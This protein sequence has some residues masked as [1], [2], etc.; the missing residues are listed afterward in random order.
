MRSLKKNAQSCEVY[1]CL[2]Q[3]S[4]EHNQNNHNH[5]YYPAFAASV[6]VTIWFF[7]QLSLKA[8]RMDGLTSCVQKASSRNEMRNSNSLSSSSLP[9]KDY[10]GTPL[11]RSNAKDIM[12]LSTMTMF[13]FSLS[14]KT[15]RSLMKNSC[16]WMQSYLYILFFMIF[17][18]G[19]IWSRIL[20][21]YSCTPA[22]KTMISQSQLSLSKQSWRQGLILT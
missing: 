10:M 20:S 13:S 8:S 15:S 9:K 21:A 7:R 3:L 22:V 6:S 16:N 18:S 2:R 4:S 5:H 1:K 14:M 11:S 19:S 17:F 12:E